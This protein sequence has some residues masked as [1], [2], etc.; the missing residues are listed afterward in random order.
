MHAN[1]RQGYGSNKCGLHAPTDLVPSDFSLLESLLN[2]QGVR[3]FGDRI[4]TLGEVPT[5]KTWSLSP[6]FRSFVG[7]FDRLLLLCRHFFLPYRHL[8]FSVPS[9]CLVAL[10]VA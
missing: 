5:L 2:V 4:L 3:H 8:T 9:L 10:G 1:S 7:A 6:T